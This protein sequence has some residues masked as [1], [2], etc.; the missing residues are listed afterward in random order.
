MSNPS[1]PPIAG[2]EAE[3]LALVQ[4]QQPVFLPATN[5]ELEQLRSGFACALH[6]HQPTIPAGANGELISHLQYMVEHPGEGDN[7]NAEAFA[8][9]YRRLA[10]IIPQLIAEGANPRIMLD[11]SG[12]L[13][14]GFQQMGRQDILEA[15]QRLACDHALQPHVEWLGTFW[16]HAV[17]PSTPI[18]DLKLQIL[19]WQHHFAAMFGDAA[20]QRVKGFSPPEMHLPNHPDTLYEFIKALRECGYRWLLVQEHSVENPDGSA[21]SQ[22]QKLVPNQLVARS[23][24]GEVASITALIKTQGSDTKLVGQMQPYYE[25]LGRGPILLGG[26]SVPA[27]VSQIADGENGGVMM[28]EFPQAFIQAHQRIAAED[29][30]AGTVAING[31]EYLE[32][33]EAAGVSAGDYP[34]IQAVQQHKLW[35]QL[36]DS[37]SAANVEVAIAELQARDSSF[38]MAGASWTNNL[39]WVEGYSNVLEPM[40]SLSVAFHQHFDPLVEADPSVTHTQSYQQALLHLLLLETSCFR[41]WGQ[42]VWTDYAS[43]IHRRGVVSLGA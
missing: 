38:S 1:L 23:S 14:W 41:Y 6:M 42:G 30:G 22:E 7:H 5:L 18:P 11:F 34:P 36:G 21:L 43:E 9:C 39:S 2:R 17:A 25:A 24:S 15:L 37:P 3:I 27:L 19:A 40:T 26:V 35:Q 20:L 10:D 32:M 4:Q 12:N 8:H 28:N 13:L 16:S 31:S 29:G 33:L